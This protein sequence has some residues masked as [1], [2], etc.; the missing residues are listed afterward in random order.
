[1]GYRYSILEITNSSNKFKLSEKTHRSRNCWDVCDKKTHPSN[2]DRRS[3]WDGIQRVGF[4][5]GSKDSTF[6]EEGLPSFP[7]FFFWSKNPRKAGRFGGKEIWRSFQHSSSESFTWWCSDKGSCKDSVDICPPIDSDQ[8]PAL[9]TYP[10]PFF[11]SDIPTFF[12]CCWSLQDMSDRGHP[13]SKCSLKWAMAVCLEWR[14]KMLS[15][16]LDRGWGNQRLVFGSTISS[17]G[18]RSLVVFWISGRY[19]YLQIY[20]SHVWKVWRPVFIFWT[21]SLSGLLTEKVTEICGC[22]AGRHAIYTHLHLYI[23]W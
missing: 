23:Y 3:R 10:I 11:Q 19:G 13:P 22:L 2:L 6:L 7:A 9:K 18:G 8:S 1:M 14:T 21:I 12:K 20:F 5:Q 15:L 16:L 4:S 17:F